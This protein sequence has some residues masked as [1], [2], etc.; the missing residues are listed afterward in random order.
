[1]IAPPVGGFGRFRRFWRAPHALAFA[2]SA[3]A[4]AVAF[5]W[6]LSIM[7]PSA[8]R[9]SEYQ[10]ILV[11]AT[12]MAAL[13]YGAADS[14]GLRWPVPSLDWMIPRSWSSFGPTGFAAAFGAILGIGGLTILRYLGY[15]ILVISAL[16]GVMP[17]PVW[18]FALFGLCRG[19]V[20]IAATV[21]SAWTA[22][23]SGPIHAGFSAA[24][25]RRFDHSASWLRGAAL[26]A[27]AAALLSTGSI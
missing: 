25:G 17:H 3:L 7:L 24:I 26:L 2:V 15:H 16:L 5:A 27:A 18:A 6:L 4:G 22:R 21:A 20:V 8:V 23:R 1:V 11:R 19:L 9:V 10:S 14:I 12:G 13:L